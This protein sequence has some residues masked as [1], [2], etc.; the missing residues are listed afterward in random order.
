A[1]R[2][3]TAA[4]KHTLQDVRVGNLPGFPRVVEPQL[5]GRLPCHIRA[6]ETHDLRLVTD[7]LLFGQLM[8]GHL[9]TDVSPPRQLVLI[10]RVAGGTVSVGEAQL[11]PSERPAS[12]YRFD[13]L[14]VDVADRV[15]RPTFFEVG[16]LPV[17]VERGDRTG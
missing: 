14:P 10:P 16:V 3:D 12:L 2:P 15:G 6:R 5:V 11:E 4:V 1:P 13:Q 9:L 17:N 8:L 7:L